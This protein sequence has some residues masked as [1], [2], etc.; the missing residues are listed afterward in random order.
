[1]LIEIQPGRRADGRPE[2]AWS[3]TRSS[4]TSKPKLERNPDEAGDHPASR[5]HRSTA[6][7][8]PSSTRLRQGRPRTR[9]ASRVKNVSIPTQREIEMFWY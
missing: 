1:M 4:T 3:S 6:T 2:A 5:D 9:S 7:W 8:W